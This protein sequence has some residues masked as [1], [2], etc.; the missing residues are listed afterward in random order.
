MFDPALG[1][2]IEH[3]PH[4]AQKADFGAFLKAQKNKPAWD[5][6]FA[7]LRDEDARRKEER[8]ELFKKASENPDLLG[9]TYSNPMQWD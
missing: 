4:D 2:I 6:K 7:K 8:E 5:D 3:K 9:D 1:K